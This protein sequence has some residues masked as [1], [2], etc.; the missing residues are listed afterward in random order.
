MLV[1]YAPLLVLLGLILGFVA[2][3]LV[4]SD[5]LGK[6]RQN[7][8]KQ[9]AYECGMVPQGTA[10]LRL[11]I[12]FYL[13]AVTFIVFDV[14]AIFLLLWATAAKDF[15]SDGAGLVIFAQIA[16]FI[17]ILVLALVYEWRKGGLKWDR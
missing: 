2:I 16:F 4:V 8:L 9:S 1:N 7:P 13:V 12:H 5:L 6:K 14:E 15:Q 11:S 10:R 17:G 3:N